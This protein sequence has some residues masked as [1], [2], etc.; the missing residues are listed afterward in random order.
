MSDK[1][2]LLKKQLDALDVKSKDFFEIYTMIS[3]KYWTFEDPDD[4]EK[5]AMVL[6]MYTERA[7]GNYEEQLIAIEKI[8]TELFLMEKDGV[9]AKKGHLVFKDKE[10][11]FSIG[12]N[13]KEVDGLD[14]MLGKAAESMENGTMKIKKKGGFPKFNFG[15]K[16]K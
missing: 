12:V 11:F 1:T 2:R 4:F 8:I 6:R 5:A 9:K 7:N 16:K 3:D 14:D 13:E 15:K 10:Y